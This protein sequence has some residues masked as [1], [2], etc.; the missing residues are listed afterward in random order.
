MKTS[1]V[2]LLICLTVLG[3]FAQ[4]AFAQAPVALQFKF[5]PG[6]TQNTLVTFNAT[7]A[8]TMEPAAPQMPNM[9]MSLQG[10]LDLTEQVAQVYPDGSADLALKM[11]RADL[12]ASAMGQKFNAR[13]QNGQI[14]LTINGQVSQ[15]PPDMNSSQWPLIGTP[16]K[17][18]MDKMGRVTD[19]TLPNIGSLGD[20]MKSSGMN[21]S[22]MMKFNQSQL[23]DHPVGVG[24]SWTQ[25]MSVPMFEG[26]PPLQ[27]KTVNTVVGYEGVGGQQTVK[28]QT[29]GSATA[30]NLKMPTPKMPAGT[31]NPNMPNMPNINAT[32]E[33]LN[34]DILGLN[35]FSPQL[36]QMMKSQQVITMKEV[37][38]MTGAA[39]GPQ[40]STMEMR[41]NI[42]I[43]GK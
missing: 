35:W 11:L 16:L 7:G 32:I 41:M 42:G 43:Y 27:V 26:S 25:N 29:K 20:I 38:N 8:M 10:N 22:D 3:L 40:R 28:I 6:Q 39:S 24:D 33:S 14:A 23:P 4:L 19:F 17:M 30:T 37:I 31:Q 13:L 2:R 9:T 18:R 5:T 36:G 34:I 21:M 15:M 12:N 1:V